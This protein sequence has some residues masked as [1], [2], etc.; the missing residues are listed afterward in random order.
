MSYGSGPAG[1]GIPEGDEIWEPGHWG[2]Q[3]FHGITPETSTASHQFRYILHEKGGADAA[4]IAEFYRQNDQIINEDR[5]IFAIQQFGNYDC[6]VDRWQISRWFVPSTLVIRNGSAKA[7]TGAQSGG[8]EQRFEFIVCHGVTPESDKVTNYFWA[9]THNFLYDDLPAA[10]QFHRQSHQVIGEDIAVFKAQ[11]EMLERQ[12]FAPIVH[13]RYDAGPLQARR[14]IDGRLA[15][16]ARTC[17][18]EKV[19]VPA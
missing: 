10:E 9:V 3:V 7:G 16:E 6:N 13:I 1:T 11:Q 4:S 18:K 12:P 17:G 15:A 19:N 5:I 14:M 8:G 2:F